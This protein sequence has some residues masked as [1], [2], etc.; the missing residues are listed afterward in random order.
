MRKGLCAT[1]ASLR[2]AN[3]AVRVSAR[4]FDEGGGS[5]GAASDDPAQVL[6]ELNA[7]YAFINTRGGKSQIMEETIGPD[8]ETKPCA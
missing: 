4:P 7:K 2:R 1:R 6:E 8:G 5:E 3:Q